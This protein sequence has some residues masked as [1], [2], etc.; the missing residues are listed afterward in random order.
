ML[1]GMTADQRGSA[2]NLRN[3]RVVLIVIAIVLAITIGVIYA[4]FY[5]GAASDAPEQP[6]VTEPPVVS[7]AP[8]A[9]EEPTASEEPVITEA[10]TATPGLDQGTDSGWVDKEAPSDGGGSSSATS[11]P[12]SDE[13]TDTEEPSSSEEPTPTG[14]EP[15]ETIPEKQGGGTDAQGDGMPS[16]QG[17]AAN[18][19][20]LST[21]A[22]AS[23][24]PQ[25]SDIGTPT[26]EDNQGDVGT[27]QAVGKP[28]ERTFPTTFV[29]ILFVLLGADIAAIVVLSVKIRSLERADT[30]AEDYR[31]TCMVSE[32][33]VA[34]TAVKL[35]MIHNVG[36]RPYQEDSLGFDYL[37]DG[38]LAV[39]ADGMG[40]LSAG[41]KVSQKIV[42]T[43]LAYSRKLQPIQMDGILE[44]MVQGV[45][46][47]VNRM[48]GPAG[49]YKSGST[50]LAVLFRKQRFHWI[51]VGDSRIYLFRNGQLTKLNQEHNLGNEL[52]NKAVRGE[53]SYEEA[54]SAKK[55]GSVTSFIGM[56]KLKYIDKS[57]RSIALERGDR[58]LLMTD[59]VFNSLPEQQMTAILS[60]IQDVQ[61]V[62]R[63]FERLIQQKAHPKQ[64]NFTALIL[65]F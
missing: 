26:A 49:I 65:G 51:T 60:Q 48:L 32:A 63:E 36:A 11:E 17:E 27:S 45:N 57:L 62:A 22:T 34:D 10:P 20:P 15:K 23:P 39:V 1:K 13:E 24:E 59:G 29:W 4:W 37:D 9:T 56:G 2:E 58:I 53:I 19:M 35:G 44:A 40:G 64:D 14:E 47:E 28:E 33:A 7:Q 8:T 61:M 52:L 38:G 43:M 21:P 50:L 25:T 46:A 6:T 16:V 41:D 5:L 3:L 42:Q 31:N 12:P 30:G 54:R 55:K 18:D